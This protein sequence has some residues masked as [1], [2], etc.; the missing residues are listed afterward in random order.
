MFPYEGIDNAWEMATPRAKRLVRKTKVNDYAQY[1]LL[2]QYRREGQDAEN[3]TR[4][5]EEIREFEQDRQ[6][7]GATKRKIL[8]SAE[9][10]V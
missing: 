3:E 4:I 8:R 7:K 2:K 1:D 6:A 10:S 5:Q 9:S